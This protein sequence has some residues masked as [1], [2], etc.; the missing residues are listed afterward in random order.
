MCTF[1][2]VRYAADYRYLIAC[3]LW[4]Q[5]PRMEVV[6]WS[7]KGW[8]G[9]G[10][11]SKTVMANRGTIFV[12]N[13]WGGI[14]FWYTTLFWTPPP[15]RR[16]SPGLYIFTTF[17]RG[18]QVFF[19][20]CRKNGTEVFHISEDVIKPLCLIREC[21]FLSKIRVYFLEWERSLHKSTLNKWWFLIKD[22]FQKGNG[23]FNYTVTRIQPRE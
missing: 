9:E 14:K 18:C 21:C 3:S 7:R 12:C 22:N 17:S 23:E 10:C 15:G 1:N 5:C 16:E 11:I 2:I 20:R 19:A 6:T 8:R 13:I 4:N